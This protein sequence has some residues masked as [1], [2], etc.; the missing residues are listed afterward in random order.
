MHSSLYLSNQAL[1]LG[2]I[3]VIKQ[4]KM[5]CNQK[6]QRVAWIKFGV[7]KIIQKFYTMDFTKFVSNVWIVIFQQ[8]IFIRVL[9]F[10]FLVTIYFRFLLIMY[11][12][13][14]NDGGMIIF[15]WS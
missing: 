9:Y 1:P 6:K 12:L 13:S 2:F 14:C 8:V 15:M 3:L 7:Y 5:L 11:N 4:F 10:R